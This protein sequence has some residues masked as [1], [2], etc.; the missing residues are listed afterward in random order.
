[1]LPSGNDQDHR[2]F[3]VP[4]RLGDFMFVPSTKI[5]LTRGQPDGSRNK[6]NPLVIVKRQREA[7]PFRI[8]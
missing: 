6:P 3:C 5:G 1:V 4:I 8:L 2:T 7:S